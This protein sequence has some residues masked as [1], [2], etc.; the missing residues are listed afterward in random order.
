[1]KRHHLMIPLLAASL[2]TSG[3]ASMDD[4]GRTRTEGTAAGAVIGGLLGYAVGDERGAAI[5]AA[6]GA[7][8]GYAIGNEV[9][10]RKQAYATTEAFLDGEI[11][12]VQQFNQTTVAYN[13]Q[14]R[15]E[16]T[17]LE[18]EADRMQARVASGEMARDEL[19][20]ERNAIAR[21]L[22]KSETLEKALARELKV[23]QR[24]L[25][26]EGG[27][28]PE[29]DPYL[30]QLSAEVEELQRNLNQLR[31]DSAQLASIDER[32]SV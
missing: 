28:R 5:G 30:A 11:A 29:D 1:M 12:H 31:D 14:V 10:K 24:I 16:I 21:R 7:G 22:E 3:C 27:S 23:Q 17:R 19:Q 26:E 2:M 13:E 15:A 6:L 25:A 18:A 32:L 20:G 4:Q 8:A 9:A